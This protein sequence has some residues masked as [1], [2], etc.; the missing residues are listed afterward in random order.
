MSDE[1]MVITWHCTHLCQTVRQYS[2][3]HRTYETY[4]RLLLRPR[5]YSKP[6]R[7]LTEN[8]Q[9]CGGCVWSTRPYVWFSCLHSQMLHVTLRDLTLKGLNEAHRLSSACCRPVVNRKF[10]QA[11]VRM[12]PTVWYWC[13]VS[14]HIGLQVSLTATYVFGLEVKQSPYRPG[15]ALR[16]P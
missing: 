9:F 6:S 14:C 5:C 3:S 15:G 10:R 16:V 13:W 1:D 4:E 8:L 2:R 12:L 7:N 11:K